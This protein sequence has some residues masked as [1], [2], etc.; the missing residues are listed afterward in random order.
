LWF[1]F[2]NKI[3]CVCLKTHNERTPFEYFLKYLDLCVHLTLPCD[4]SSS[5]KIVS[6]E[7]NKD[8]AGA[9]MELQDDIRR[10]TE[11]TMADVISFAGAEAIESLGGPTVVVQLGKLDKDAGTPMRIYDLKDGPETIQAFRNSGLTEPEVALLLGAVEAM[12]RVVDTIAVDHVDE[13]TEEDNEMGDSQVDIP[14]SFGAPSNIYG[15]PLGQLDNSVFESLLQTKTGVWANDDNVREWVLRYQKSGF[16]KDLPRAYN[17]LV[18][19]EV[20]R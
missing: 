11:V 7:E 15:R 16:F 8:L 20:P 6:E 5:G 18:G 1:F 13:Q 14:T 9:A 17:K 4:Q 3:P 2:A 19:S 12:E 10:S